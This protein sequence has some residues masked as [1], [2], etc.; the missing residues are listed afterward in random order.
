MKIIKTILAVTCLL[1]L[2]VANAADHEGKI[3]QYQLNSNLSDRVCVYMDPL[4]PDHW[5]CLH[6]SNLLFSELNALILSAYMGSKT[7][8]VSDTALKIDIVT[9]K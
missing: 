3:V 4:H 5:V 6:K 7:C 8:V 1:V 2:S 9:C